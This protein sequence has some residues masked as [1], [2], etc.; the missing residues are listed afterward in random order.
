VECDG[1]G[2]SLKKNLVILFLPKASPDG[3]ER[4]LPYAL[5]YLER[6]LRNLGLEIILI[7]ESLQPEYRTVLAQKGD[8][9]L[10]AGV[11]ALTGLQIVGGIA[12][13]KAVREHCSAPIVWG[14]WHPTLLPE[15][16]LQEPY[17]DFV[18]LGQG[19]RPLRQL[20]ERLLNGHDYSDIPGLGFKQGPATKVN[21]PSPCRDINAFAR[22]NLHLL[23]PGKYVC[24]TAYSKRCL[25]YFASH[26]CPFDC[27]F[28][29]VAAVYRHHW[30]PKPVAQIIEDLQFLKEAAAIDSVAFEDDNFFVNA[31]FAREVAQAMIDARLN[32]K[33][34]TGAHAHVFTTHFT[35][36]DLR[37]FVQSG[38]RQIYIGAESGDQKVLDILDKRS[39]V[40]ETFRF[41]EMLKPHGIIPRLSTMVCLPMNPSRDFDLTLEMIRRAK[42]LQPNLG[43]N[44]FFYTPY[45][46]TGLYDRA[47][48]KGFVPPQR[49]GDW[50]NHTLGTSNYPWMPKRCPQRLRVFRDGYIRMLDPLAYK[51]LASPAFR[52]MAYPIN[53]VLFA[54]TWLRFKMAF[55]RL[56]VDAILFLKLLRLYRKL[57]GA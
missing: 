2:N 6:S 11:S 3:S 42:L 26:G 20:V 1:A 29:S 50:A 17:V 13:S 39:K 22:I 18:V 54:I 49:L 37:L 44:V 35:A 47:R 36:E 16:T 21:P 41:I 23:D 7:D 30:H 33:W 8:R 53:K 12:F 25:H 10:L 57:N 40:E 43:V 14:G 4:R 31:N 32:L 56:P 5:L 52:L 28:C 51:R 38:C 19:E 46:G 27:T 9:I 15:Q 34:N 45:P 24:K 55:F 48:E